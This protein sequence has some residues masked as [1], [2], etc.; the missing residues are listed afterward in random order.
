MGSPNNLDALRVYIEANLLDGDAIQA[1]QMIASIEI[2]EVMQEYITAQLATQKQQLLG[3]VR[4]MLKDDEQ[5]SNGRYNLKVEL[6]A[7]L[8]ALEQRG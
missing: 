5:D 1:G 2:L 4:E 3:E 8:D 7:N 6:L